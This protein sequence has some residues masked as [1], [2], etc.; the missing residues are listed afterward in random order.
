M[1]TFI[2][3]TETDFYRLRTPRQRRR[4]VLTHRDKQLLA[5]HRRRKALW[6]QRRDRPL[7]PLEPPVMRGWKRSFVLRDDVARRP[8]AAFYER[9]LERINTVQYSH[10]RDFKKKRR[11]QGRKIHVARDQYLKRLELWEWQKAGFTPQE[12]ALFDLV[13]AP[14]PYRPGTWVYRYVFREAWR[15]VLRIRPN[16]ITHTRL[17]NAEAEATEKAIDNYL[18]RQDKRNRL[19]KL[20]DGSS[21]RNRWKAWK[22]ADPHYPRRRPFRNIPLHGLL[23]E[24]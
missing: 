18:E 8:D 7:V 11:S 1:N 23:P 4:A 15:Y 14:C 2:P 5:L 13:E 21:C 19:N 16:R 3:Q 12:A 9:I 6:Q 20:L 24:D 22:P 17:H 10:R